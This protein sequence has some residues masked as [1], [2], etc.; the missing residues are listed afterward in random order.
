MVRTEDAVTIVPVFEEV[1]V[2]EKRLVLKREIRIRKRPTSET[3]AIPV[4]LRKQ[5]VEVERQ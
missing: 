5:R 1:L 4:S 2:V 3:V